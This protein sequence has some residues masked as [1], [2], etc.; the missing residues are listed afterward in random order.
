MTLLPRRATPVTYRVRVDLARTRPPVWRRLE[1]NSDLTLDAVH[2]VLQTA[3]GWSN[4]HLHAFRRLGTAA[5]RAEPFLLNAFD[6]SE[7]DPGTPEADVHLDQVLAD[8]G[9]RLG[10]TYDFGDGW[11]HVVRLEEVRERPPGAPDA[12]C[13]SGRRACPP[14]DCGGPGGYAELLYAL[15]TRVDGAPVAPHLRELLDTHGDLRPAEFSAEAVNEELVHGPRPPELPGV[16]SHPELH[17]DGL[18]G[19]VT[20]LLSRL[21][22]DTARTVHDLARRALPHGT[23]AAAL[24]PEEL[25]EITRDVR[26]LLDR[27]GEEGVTLTGAGYLPPAVV[28][29]AFEALRLDDTWIGTGNREVHTLPVLVFRTAVQDLGLLRKH[30]GRLLVTPAGRSLRTDPARLVG[31][32]AARLPAGR[33]DAAQVAGTLA[34]LGVAAGDA[35]VHDRITPLGVEVLTALGWATAA[36][37]LTRGDVF[38]AA[39][40]TLDVL[41]RTGVAAYRS[42]LAS[43]AKQSP[44]ARKFAR[45]VLTTPR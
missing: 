30:R 38:D 10:Y 3:M 29:D 21:P 6:V 25:A 35:T 4:S 43:G 27:I 24:S 37:P 2:D 5:G 23:L 18:P 15:A 11:D 13:L 32:I 40:P 39:R 1:V 44:A 36:G 41:E 17:V 26:W 42:R 33:D 19:I 9:D 14:E 28:Q 20:D 16:P 31:H 22:L 45:L 7:G 12:L 8:P 34:L